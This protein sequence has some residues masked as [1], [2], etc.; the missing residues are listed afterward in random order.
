MSKNFCL[1]NNKE[2][3]KV[4]LGVNISI[5]KALLLKHDCKQTL[6]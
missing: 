5:I 4:I 6:V 2:R 3:K 1:S